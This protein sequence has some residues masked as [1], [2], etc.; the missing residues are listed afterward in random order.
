MKCS[1]DALGRRGIFAVSFF[2]K[3][4]WSGPLLRRNFLKINENPFFKTPA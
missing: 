1:G 2:L 3:T 4:L